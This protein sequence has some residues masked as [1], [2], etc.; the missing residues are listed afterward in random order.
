MEVTTSAAASS[1]SHYLNDFAV[2]SGKVAVHWF[3]QSSFALKT[4]DGAIIL[5]DPYFP[6]DRPEGKFIHREPL[7]TPM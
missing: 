7:L 5:I 2:P 6:R 3:G 1:M 4:P